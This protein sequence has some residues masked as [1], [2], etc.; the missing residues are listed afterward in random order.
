MK[1][2]RQKGQI[3]I[4]AIVFLAILVTISGAL[5][6]YTYQNTHGISQS[7]AKNQ[8]TVLAQAGINKAIYQLNQD[9]TYSGESNTAL[10]SGTFTTTVA[11][12]DSSTKR[13]TVTSYVPNSTSP[14]ATQTLRANVAIDTTQIAFNTGVQVGAGG[15]V[16]DNNSIV[17]GNIFSNGNITGSGSI[18]GDAI[19]AQGSSPTADQQWT[20]QNSDFNF[21]NVA[22][23][24]D[25]AESFEPSASD[26]LTKVQVY[27]KKFGS[28]GD[29]TVRIM[30]DNSGSPSKTVVVTGNIAASTV[31]GSY[32]WAEATFASPP[33]LSA[34]VTY[35]LMISAASINASNYYY[36]GT[37]NNNGFGNGQCKYSTNYN[38]SSPSWTAASGDCDFK[39][40]MGGVTTYFDG[41]TNVGGNLTATEIRDCGTVS[42]TAYYNTVFTS[43]SASSSVGSTSIPGPEPMPISQAQIDDWEA[44]ASAGGVI[45]GNH[46]VLGVETLGP[47]EIDGDLILDNN[48]TLYMTGPIWV[49][50]N[51]TISNNAIARVDASLGNAGTVL[52]ADNPSDPTGSGTITVSNNGNVLGNGNANSF[53]L[54]LSASSNL[55]GAINVQNNAASAIFYASNGSIE[56][57]NNAGGNQM[58]G[59]KV[60]LNNNATVTYA[61]GLANA[62]FANGPGGAWAFVPGS[63]YISP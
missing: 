32:G 36:W 54:V 53:P 38:A 25:V 41:S 43:C 1:K 59:Y 6:G 35:W 12:I 9:S 30:T 48:V 62:S 11:T 17:T 42:G 34:N 60:H 52:I 39:T 58:T 29:L 15:L 8:A 7:Y 56:V 37:D 50:G 26:V 2:T 3:I 10:G 4:I 49:K 20:Q 18:T 27:I 45:S 47:V 13:L 61:N 51:I 57:S 24:K 21:G 23:R 63:Y 55:S 14:K 31:T 46:T 28:P 5:I 40:F 33:N 44:T 22:S 16:M 19:V